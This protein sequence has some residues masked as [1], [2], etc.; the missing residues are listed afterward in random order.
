MARKFIELKAGRMEKCFPDEPTF[1][2]LGR[3][4][5]APLAIR[6]WIEARILTG[7]NVR[8]DAQIHEAWMLVLMMEREQSEWSKLAHAPTDDPPPYPDVELTE[9][10]ASFE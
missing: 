4:A 2:L 7:K 6:S 8:T 3:D 9:E 1:V 5:C 10:E